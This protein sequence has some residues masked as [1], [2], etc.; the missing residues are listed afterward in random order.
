VKTKNIT[1]E[2][3]APNPHIFGP[4]VLNGAAPQVYHFDYQHGKIL[5]YNIKLLPPTLQNS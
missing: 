4:F 2:C 5:D 3:F 1:W